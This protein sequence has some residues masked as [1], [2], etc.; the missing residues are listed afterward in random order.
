MNSIQLQLR[1]LSRLCEK[2]KIAYALLGG[3]AVAFYGE[4]R[5]SFDIDINILLGNKRLKGFLKTAREFGF[6]PLPPALKKFIAATGVIP[7]RFSKNGVTGRCDFIIAQNP[8]EYAGIKR[9]FTRNIY[10]IKLKMIRCEDLVLHK[11]TSDRP[12]DLEDLR[13][14]LIRQRGKLD[15]EYIRGWLKKIDKLSDNHKLLKLFRGMLSSL[16]Y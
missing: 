5:M 4:P 12:R 13:G 6:I 8:L 7:M 10:A 16:A 3:L 2:T 1:Q 11:I 14:I 15:L 9:A